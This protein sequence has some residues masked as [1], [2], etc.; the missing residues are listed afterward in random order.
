MKHLWTLLGGVG[1][2]VASGA[3]ASA[4][5]DE[6]KRSV[7]LYAPRWQETP[8]SAKRST[9]AESRF[10]SPSRFST[11]IVTRCSALAA[12][13][14]T[15]QTPPP[16]FSFRRAQRPN[17]PYLLATAVTMGIAMLTCLARA[18]VMTSG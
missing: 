14:Q 16:R 15:R 13:R 2:I 12:P 7:T 9:S 10:I 4:Q 18:I 3:I 8:S 11:I 17:Y 5:A 6:D 1:V